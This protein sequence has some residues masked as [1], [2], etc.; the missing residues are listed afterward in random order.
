MNRLLQLTETKKH[1]DDF[2]GYQIGANIDVN[3]SSPTYGAYNIL[4]KP[5]NMK[6]DMKQI[7]SFSLTVK[8]Q[9]KRHS[10]K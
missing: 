3:P 10:P 5:A 8:N 4:I 9:D 6:M 7:S 2:K 1:Y